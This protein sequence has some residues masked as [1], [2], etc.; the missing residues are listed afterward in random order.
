LG[1]IGD[2][3]EKRETISIDPPDNIDRDLNYSSKTTIARNVAIENQWQ[4]S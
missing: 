4:I 2:E 1:S 3:Q